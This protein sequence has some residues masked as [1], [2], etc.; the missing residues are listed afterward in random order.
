MTRPSNACP[1]A[2][3][4]VTGADLDGDHWVEPDVSVY[5]TASRR[6]YREP[7][8]SR[9]S[10]SDLRRNVSCWLRCSFVFRQSLP[11]PSI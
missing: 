6:F 8:S 9:D 2:S 5:E 1:G 7:A 11:R 4:V 3:E 10:G